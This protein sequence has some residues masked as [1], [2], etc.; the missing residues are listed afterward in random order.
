[1]SHPGHKHD[2]YGNPEDLKEY[3]ERL[4]GSDR[5]AWQKPDEVVAALSLRPGDVACEIGAGTGYFSLRLARAVGERGHVFA[6][7]AH[8]RMLEVL[9]ERIVAA[10]VSNLTPVFALAEDPLLPPAS[11]DMAL[12][13]NTFHHFP[14]GVAYLRRLVRALKPDG[15]IVNIDFREGELPVGPPPEQKLSRDA[16]LRTAHEAGLRLH[17][18]KSFLPYQYFLVMRPS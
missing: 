17:S 15:R 1:M 8:P 3:L 18:E 2:R 11:C 14:D 13:V 16:F 6:V 10:R 5:A 9:R 7:E 4:E 12:I